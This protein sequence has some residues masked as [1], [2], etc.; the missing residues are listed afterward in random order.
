LTPPRTIR[1]LAVI[2]GALLLGGGAGAA[3]A[4]AAPAPASLSADD[5]ALVDKAAAYLSGLSEMKGRF[6]QT[7][8]RGNVTQ[9][10]LYLARPGKARFAYDPPSGQLVVSDGY[11]VSI[12][13]PRLKT[14]DRY[15]LGATPLALFLAK[16]VRTDRGVEIMR[17][18]RFVDGFAVTARDAR[19]PR[20]GQVTLTFSQG[21]TRLKQ[22]SLID[23]QGQ[24][25]S[26]KITSLEPAV[27][28]DPGLFVLRDPRPPRAG[29]AA[30]P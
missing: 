20:A 12:L 26:I 28:L 19:H 7:D 24:T 21:P 18:D 5:Q 8:S 25:T 1:L 23:A 30:H 17:V 4:P 14:F 16:D 11:N 2:A 6:V 13:D 22:W 3:P 9:G 27:G 15:P 10:A 29:T